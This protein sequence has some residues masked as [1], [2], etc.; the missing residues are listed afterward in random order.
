MSNRKTVWL[1]FAAAMALG[2]V[3]C[4][5]D[6]GTNG[7]GGTGGMEPGNAMVTVVHLAPEVPS[8]ADTRVDILV[9]GA[10]AIEDLA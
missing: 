2:L 5:D 4:S 6:G 8:P 10:A 1:S 7:T 3:G 9:N